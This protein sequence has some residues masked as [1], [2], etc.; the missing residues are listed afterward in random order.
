MIK[1]TTINDDAGN[2]DDD[3]EGDD[4]VADNSVNANP[5][6]PPL[7]AFTSDSQCGSGAAL[8]QAVNP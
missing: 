6:D 7:F 8:G 2:V 1:T 5:P 3:D 4:V